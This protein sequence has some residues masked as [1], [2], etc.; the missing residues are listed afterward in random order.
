[1]WRFNTLLQLMF[2]LLIHLLVFKMS[3]SDKAADLNCKEA[4]KEKNGFN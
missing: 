3:F 1:M 4:G 2:I